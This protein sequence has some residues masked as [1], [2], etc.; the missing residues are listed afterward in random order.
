MLNF[1][2]K[3]TDSEA[4][5]LSPVTL[6]FVGDAVYSLYVREKFVLE[7]DSSANT[8]QRLTCEKV[9]AHGQNITLAEIMPYFTEEEAAVFKRGRNAKKSTRSKSASVEEYNNSTGFEAVLGY[10]YLTARYDR[11]DELLNGRKSL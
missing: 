7:A 3:V 6:A 11:I 4:K 2:T 1:L 10:L 5:N 9:S 8:L